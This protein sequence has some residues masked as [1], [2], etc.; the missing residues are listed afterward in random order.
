MSTIHPVDTP[1]S[2]PP[3]LESPL[4]LNDPT[5][6]S[7]PGPSPSVLSDFLFEADLLKNRYFE[8]NILAASENLLVESFTEMRE[9]VRIEEGSRFEEDLLENIE[10]MSTELL[11][12]K[13]AEQ[14]KKKGKPKSKKS[15]AKEVTSSKKR[16]N[17]EP[18]KKIS[19]ER[20]K[21]RKEVSLDS[22]EHIKVAKK[23]IVDNLRLL[24]VLSGRVFD[25]EIITKLGM[26]TLAD[27]VEIH[28]WT[29]LFMT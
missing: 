12:R 19:K 20:S 29:H 21:R 22:E 8:Y 15:L 6:S 3:T 17:K 25:R 16:E 10:P 24:K 14:E 7:Q 11:K 2:S 1:E 27:A 26:S 4:D 28:S 13:K 9:G 23:E 5:P 18:V